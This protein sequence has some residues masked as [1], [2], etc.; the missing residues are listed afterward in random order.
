MSLILNEGAFH[1]EQK[2]AQMFN[3]CF[4]H[5]Q[6]YLYRKFFNIRRQ[7]I[8]GFFTGHSKK[9]QVNHIEKVFND[10]IINTI[11]QIESQQTAN[12]E[13]DDGDTQEATEDKISQ[14]FGY[15]KQEEQNLVKEKVKQTQNHRQV[16]VETIDV[17][18]NN[19][20]NLNGEKIRMI[21]GFYLN[22]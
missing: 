12:K 15:A 7:S 16:D 3:Y 22:S 2:P 4:V 10:M 13:K 9:K 18:N 17:N 14:D 5:V 21:T 8:T 20:T 6:L 1:L 11:Q 19:C